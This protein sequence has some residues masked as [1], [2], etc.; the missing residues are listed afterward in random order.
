MISPKLQR[1][2]QPPTDVNTDHCHAVNCF[3]IHGMI[4]GVLYSGVQTRFAQTC[5]PRAE[6]KSPSITLMNLIKQLKSVPKVYILYVRGHESL[7]SFRECHTFQVRSL[8]CILII[9]LL[10]LFSEKR[11]FM[12]SY[13]LEKGRPA[14]RC[15]HD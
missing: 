15:F 11:V 2:T 12:P 14:L 6:W 13:S 4:S 10:N 7:Q 8:S 5:G 1:G 3:K 9:F